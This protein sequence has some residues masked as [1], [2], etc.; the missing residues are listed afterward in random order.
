[1][2]DKYLTLNGRETIFQDADHVRSEFEKQ[3]G[4]MYKRVGKNR[5]GVVLDRQKWE[6]FPVKLSWE[7]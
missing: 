2:D 4:T 3:H 6:Q 1:M 7:E 5:A